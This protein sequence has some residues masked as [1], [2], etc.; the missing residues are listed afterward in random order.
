M[1]S[2]RGFVMYMVKYSLWR[3]GGMLAF[4]RAKMPPILDHWL[5]VV[6]YPLFACTQE[7]NHRMLHLQPQSPA[8]N[9]ARSSHRYLSLCLLTA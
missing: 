4:I 8:V 1:Q 9:D 3:R 5:D 2:I 7:R 6:P